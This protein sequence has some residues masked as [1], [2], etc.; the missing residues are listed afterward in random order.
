MP[1]KSVAMQSNTEFHEFAISI[2]IILSQ[3]SDGVSKVIFNSHLM[4]DCS[5][6]AIQE[7]VYLCYLINQTLGF[8]CVLLINQ[9]NFSRRLRFA[10]INHCQTL[11]NETTPAAVR[12]DAVP[13]G[14]S[15]FP[16]S[17]ISS[18]CSLQ[19]TPV[20]TVSSVYTTTTATYT[21][22]GVHTT[23]VLATST[24]SET[25]TVVS[26]TT[27][28]VASSAP[29]STI[30]YMTFSIEINAGANYCLS[31]DSTHMTDNYYQKSKRETFTVTADGYLY[32]VTNDSY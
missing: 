26:T 7:F 23:T 15:G 27:I 4:I 30:G 31:D 8:G 12:R 2:S 29:T 9:P 32:S 25:T 6:P 18:A 20:T 21:S 16:A 1:M 19:A 5:R 24:V 14:L 13:A 22:G 28:Q 11:P 10:T 3:L 17:V